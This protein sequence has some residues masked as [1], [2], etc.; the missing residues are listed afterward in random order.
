MEN[1]N[2]C[3]RI[4]E[5]FLRT[6][7]FNLAPVFLTELIRRHTDHLLGGRSHLWTW[8]SYSM[9]RVRS[10][11]PN[12]V[13][14]WFL[15]RTAQWYQLTPNSKSLSP[16]IIEEAD[17]LQPCALIY[18]PLQLP[19]EAKQS[20]DGGSWYSELCMVWC[21]TCEVPEAVFPAQLRETSRAQFAVRRPL[22]GIAGTFWEPSGFRFSGSPQRSR[23]LIFNN[24][25]KWV[26]YH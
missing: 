7:G 25:T 26:W 21:S 23:K 9:R 15:S 16:L 8:C 22:E 2:K 11:R 5:M 13:S 10:G 4:F 24:S 19:K 20:R 14:P 12:K 3:Q 1:K 18:D 17:G 6:Y